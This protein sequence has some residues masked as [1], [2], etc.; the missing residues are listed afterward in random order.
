MDTETLEN[1][2]KARAQ[3]LRKNVPPNPSSSAPPTLS[4]TSASDSKISSGPPSRSASAE[5]LPRAASKPD[6]TIDEESAKNFPPLPPAESLRSLPP[7][8]PQ[9]KVV[10][11]ELRANASM[12]PLDDSS[13]QLKKQFLPDAPPIESHP[14]KPSYDPNEAGEILGT[15]KIIAS[16]TSEAKHD[17]DRFSDSA[18]DENSEAG[19]DDDWENDEQATKDGDTN[20]KRFGDLAAR[21]RTWLACLEIPLGSRSIVEELQSGIV[22]CKVLAKISGRP[23]IMEQVSQ[24]YSPA[25]ANLTEWKNLELFLAKSKEIYSSLADASCNPQ[26]IYNQSDVPNFLAFVYLLAKGSGTRLE[27]LE[28][29]QVP[30]EKDIQVLRRQKGSVL[31]NAL[32]IIDED[33]HRKASPVYAWLK[34]AK[35]DQYFQLFEQRGWDDLEKIGLMEEEDIRAIVG[36]EKDG[37]VKLLMRR[38]ADL[39][40]LRQWLASA[41]LDHTLQMQDVSPF[42]PADDPSG[43]ELSKFDAK[44]KL[45][46]SKMKKHALKG[47]ESGYS[48]AKHLVEAV[49]PAFAP[50]VVIDFSSNGVAVVGLAGS[51]VPVCDFKMDPTKEFPDNVLEVVQRAVTK[52]G[53][54]LARR[55]KRIFVCGIMAGPVLQKALRKLAPRGL[56]V[57][58][59]KSTAALALRAVGLADG[60]SLDLDHSLVARAIAVNGGR[61]IPQGFATAVISGTQQEDESAKRRE[62]ALMG[63]VSSCLAE[64]G[65]GPTIAKRVRGGL[66]VTGTKLQLTPGIV[67]RFSSGMFHVSPVARWGAASQVASHPDFQHRWTI[68]RGSDDSVPRA[69]EEMLFPLMSESTRRHLASQAF[70]SATTLERLLTMKEEAAKL[71]E[72]NAQNA[73]KPQ[74]AKLPGSPSKSSPPTTS[75][76]PRSAPPERP[77]RPSKVTKTRHSAPKNEPSLLGVNGPPSKHVEASPPPELAVVH[78]V[79]PEDMQT[80]ITVVDS[81]VAQLL[82]HIT[83]TVAVNEFRLFLLDDM[84]FKNGEITN[85]KF[86][87]VLKALPPPLRKIMK[88]AGFI[89]MDEEEE[90]VEEAER[91]EEED[92]DFLMNML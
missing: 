15:T 37:H 21:I 26:D 48:V 28:N 87:D 75:G 77:S 44:L 70:A 64:C 9:E 47:L 61:A 67:K 74:F 68:P 76:S 39:S 22:L 79:V 83:D 33:E 81:H 66:V 49:S 14:P 89:F 25:L 91:G 90:V 55:S 18:S 46:E 13:V 8:P 53:K 73:R 16:V 17:H 23:D 72:L 69:Q 62:K 54:D 32:T 1:E 63:M 92:G 35:M 3:K 36:S 31:A 41:Y 19:Y 71:D 29:V 5:M 60:V 12:A 78:A 10:S 57:C 7:L 38:V 86:S 20:V 59:P 65:Y 80:N 51:L 82:E 85:K 42:V 4:S 88:S 24:D 50:A 84:S 58:G 45:M 40:I 34:E 52:L 30:F 43:P 27:K 11:A 6:M 2:L 56:F